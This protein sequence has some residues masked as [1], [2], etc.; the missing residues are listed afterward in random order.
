VT[1]AL[2][3]DLCEALVMFDQSYGCEDVVGVSIAKGH[4]VV[5]LFGAAEST[6]AS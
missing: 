4:H 3:T 1:A 5:A 6:L 2:H